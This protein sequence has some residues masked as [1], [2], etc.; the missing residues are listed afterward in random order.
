M[1][2]T[3]TM[4]PFATVSDLRERWPGFPVGADAHAS[5][6]LEDASQ[7]ILDTVPS[8]KFAPAATLRRITCAM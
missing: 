5:V 4:P 6:L 1:D 2:A 3:E 7:L 8:A